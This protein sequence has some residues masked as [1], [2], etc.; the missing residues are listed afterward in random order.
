M[1]GIEI[2][3]RGM[4]IM[5]SLEPCTL[6]IPDLLETEPRIFMANERTYLKWA[7][8]C[9]IVL[10]LGMGMVRAGIEPTMGIVMIVFSVMILFR[11]FYIFKVRM[12][13]IKDNE[14]DRYP[15]YDRYNPHFLMIMLVVAAVVVIVKNGMHIVGLT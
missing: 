9:F 15:F 14:F 1:I 10:L 7:R 12:E 8:M 5:G 13:M 4:D 6:V 3:R 11:A 2:A